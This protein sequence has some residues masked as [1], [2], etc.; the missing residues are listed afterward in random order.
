[1]SKIIVKDLE[2]PASTSNKIYIASGSQL[3][4]A[5]SPGG[6]GAINLAVD[7]G[8]ITSGTVTAARLPVGTI[9]NSEMFTNNTRTVLSNS[10]DHDMWSVSYTKKLVDSILVVHAHGMFGGDTAS[11]CC[12][13]FLEIDGT[14]YYSCN[15]EYNAGDT[16][17][18][19]AFK[20]FAQ[21]QVST[22]GAK[23]IVVGWKTANGNTGDRPRE[24]WNPNSTEDARANQQQSVIQ[25]TEVT[26]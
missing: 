8:D 19:T 10:A 2:G 5:G 11:G 23:T 16:P 18:F 3:D 12:G 13:F 4:I 20:G 24:V 21:K 26:V 9:I 1:M 25:V 7:G 15:Y 6:A 14:K 22:S 17:Y